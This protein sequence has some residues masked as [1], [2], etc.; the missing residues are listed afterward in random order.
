[1]KLNFLG[2]GTGSS[3]NHTNAYFKIDGSIFFIDCSM[4][5]IEKILKLA[6]EFNNIY[7]FITHM[8]YDHCSGL[9]MLIQKLYLENNIK[10]I[11]CVAPE[12]ISDI[13][14]F[15][16]V[17]ESNKQQYI[18]K[19]IS[20]RFISVSKSINAM[21]I[22]TTHT[23]NCISYGYAFEMEDEIIVYTGDT[24]T[25]EN[26]VKCIKNYS[27]YGRIKLYTE[28]YHEDYIGENAKHLSLKQQ[29]NILESLPK[30]VKVY[31]MHMNDPN[32]LK[33]AVLKLKKNYEIVSVE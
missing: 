9:G 5:N 29:I 16:I 4:L 1:M 2:N 17:Q 21:S 7:I 10:P 31:F 15:L 30:H 28:M 12:L 25:L 20:N 8:H 27:Y 18:I 19:E 6:K 14:N 24:N 22:K 32:G 11:I 23:P 3:Y 26:F 13:E 33:N